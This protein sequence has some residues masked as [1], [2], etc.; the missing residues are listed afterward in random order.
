MYVDAVTFW[1]KGTIRSTYRLVSEERKQVETYADKGEKEPVDKL[2]NSLRRK[3][4]DITIDPRIK[5][6]REMSGATTMLDYTRSA[7]SEVGAHL[8]TMREQVTAYYAQGASDE[9][10]AA[11]KELF[12][13][14]KAEIVTIVD[15][16]EYDGKKVLQDSSA[17]GL[18]SQLVGPL[19]YNTEF[20]ISFEADVIIDVSALDISVG[21]STVDNA[22]L[23][24]ETRYE[25]FTSKLKAYVQG[26]SSQVGM[27]L[28]STQFYNGNEGILTEAEASTLAKYS[29]NWVNDESAKFFGASKVPPRDNVIALLTEKEEK[30]T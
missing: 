27:I 14:A 16:S 5:L 23:D 13:E 4:L 7:L 21:E 15:V 20:S 11:A 1:N 6:S 28:N 3:L 8:D 2:S 22:L 9:D 17:D 29:K 24:Q 26:V 10:K 12:D 25:K 19:E 30:E 18:Y